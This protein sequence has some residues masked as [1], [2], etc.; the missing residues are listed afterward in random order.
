MGGEGRAGGTSG[1]AAGV[2]LVNFYGSLSLQGATVPDNLALGGGPGGEGNGGGVFR[3]GGTYSAD[4]TT[5]IAKNHA[6]TSGD[7][8]AP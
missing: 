1:G 7:N 4:G 5:V 3:M 2:G 8:V 6:S